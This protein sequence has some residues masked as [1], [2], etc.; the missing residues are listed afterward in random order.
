MLYNIYI[1]NISKMY[2]LLNYYLWGLLMEEW[3]KPPGMRVFTDFSTGLGRLP[4]ALNLNGYLPYSQHK[5]SPTFTW[6]AFIKEYIQPVCCMA[7]PTLTAMSGGDALQALT[8]HCCPWLF[9]I[10]SAWLKRA[11]REISGKFTCAESCR[12]FQSFKKK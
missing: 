10:V 9:L 4:D 3:T 6:V 12:M 2:K 8:P 5:F 1:I 11:D 7:P